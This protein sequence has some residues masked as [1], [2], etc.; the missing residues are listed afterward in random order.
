M[1][2]QRK[3]NSSHVSFDFLL[4]TFMSYFNFTRGILNIQQQKFE[5]WRGRPRMKVS[6]TILTPASFFS[7]RI[8][9]MKTGG[10]CFLEVLEDISYCFFQLVIHSIWQPNTRYPNLIF[11]TNTLLKSIL[12]QGVLMERNIGYLWRVGWI[13]LME[14]NWTEILKFTLWIT[15]TSSYQMHVFK[16]KKKKK[17][18]KCWAYRRKENHDNHGSSPQLYHSYYMYNHL[19]CPQ[20]QWIS[21]IFMALYQICFGPNVLFPSLCTCKMQMRLLLLFVKLCEIYREKRTVLMVS[22]N[23]SISFLALVVLPKGIFFNKT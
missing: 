4:N 17:H 14:L 19:K 1:A 5:G 22:A 20:T 16:T 3:C 2:T 6:C 10:L 7:D 9:G 13:A 8:I 23:T 21:Q 12:L 18:K 15:I 11:S